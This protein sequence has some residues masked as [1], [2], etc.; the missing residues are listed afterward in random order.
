MYIQIGILGRSADDIYLYQ[1][2]YSVDPILLLSAYV[3]THSGHKTPR[4]SCRQSPGCWSRLKGNFSMLHWE[5]NN[6]TY[7]KNN[8]KAINDK[9]E[10]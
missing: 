5:L 1:C 8:P 3:Y 7:I 10:V 2:S 4:G 9:R 6:K